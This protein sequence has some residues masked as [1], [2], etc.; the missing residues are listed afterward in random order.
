MAEPIL[1]AGKA[2]FLSSFRGVLAL[3]V[4]LLGFTFAP[5]AAQANTRDGT[6][7]PIKL[8]A[9]FQASVYASGLAKP[10]LM[11]VA[12]NGDVALSD[13]KSGKIYMLRGS[14]KATATVYAS[15]LNI[16][17]GLAFHGG[18]LYVATTDAVLRYP[19]RSGDTHASG[20]SQKVVALSGG[21]E[22]VTRT[23][24]FGPDG[25]MY[26]STGS[27]CNAC[28]ETDPHR[29]SVWSYTADGKDG[30]VYASGLRN[31]VGMAWKGGALYVSN[32]GRDYLGDTTPPE[33]FYRL[34]Q[35][36]FYGW[37]TCFTVGSKVVNDPAYHKADCR[38]ATAAF[39]T[40][41]A[42]SAPMD[43]ALYTGNMFPAAYQGKFL[44]ALHGSSMNAVPVGDKLVLIDP[45][46][47]KVSDFMTGLLHTDVYTNRPVGL[48]VLPDGS[49]LVSDDWAGKVYRV[50]YGK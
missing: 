45:S 23:L 21:G 29:A 33:G 18:Y 42:H 10:R 13:M 16:P 8:P 14:Q 49:L 3:M 6:L 11:A 1:G 40:V 48:A 31:A 25:R 43:L 2:D 47:G 46:T 27:S 28:R 15:G 34:K 19:Y 30:R 36:G 24:S 17:H 12:P 9:G 50:T 32:N 37:P 26:V 5:A 41:H 35:G 22:H 39:A 20:A 4:V 7:P 38:G 44:A